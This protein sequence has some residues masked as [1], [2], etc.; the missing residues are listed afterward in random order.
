[1]F[2]PTPVEASTVMHTVLDQLMKFGHRDLPVPMGRQPGIEDWG[3]REEGKAKRHLA[4]V[5]G[6][7]DS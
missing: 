5:M 6:V 7:R 4:N 3:R 2:E 1:M